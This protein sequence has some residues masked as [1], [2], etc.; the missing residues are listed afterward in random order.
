MTMDPVH[1][2]SSG[3]E[4]FT[5]DGDKLGTVKEVEAGAI[6]IDAPLQP[7][8]WLRRDDVLS[9]TNERVTMSFNK[10]G[11]DEAKTDRAETS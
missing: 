7:D 4:V 2:L 11:L 8:Y 9:Y 6:K 10:D 5:L 1:D 3:L